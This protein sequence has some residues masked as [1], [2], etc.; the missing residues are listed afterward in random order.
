[1][2]S[3]LNKI[4]KLFFDRAVQ[5]LS[6]GTL[7]FTRPVALEFIEECQK[8]R[9]SV[10]GIDGFLIGK[11]IQPIKGFTITEDSIQPSQENSIDFSREPYNYNDFA[12]DKI[13]EEAIN[14]IKGRPDNIYYEIVCGEN[15]V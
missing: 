13:Y 4:E 2:K 9:V 12:T 14:F 7:I 15:E 11:D 10:F 1:M 5:R 6:G 8:Q 3:D